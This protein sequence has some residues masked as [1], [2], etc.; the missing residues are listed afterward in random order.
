MRHPSF[1]RLTALAAGLLLSTAAA[2]ADPA[3]LARAHGQAGVTCAQCH[4]AGGGKVRLDD[5]ETA[6][7]AAC[8]KC[9]GDLATLGAGSKEAINAHASH[10]GAIACTVCHRGHEASRPYCMNCHAFEMKIPFASAPARPRAPRASRAERTDVVVVGSGAAGMVAALTARESGARV[11]VLEKQPVTGGN[12]M[13]AAGGM[14]AAGTPQQARLGI[15]DSVEL[16]REDT[17]KGGRNLGDPE[18][19]GILARE[20]AASVAYL[21]SLGAD[22]SDVG[23]LGGATAARAHRPSGGAAVGAHIVGVLRKA[24]ASRKV[25]VRVNS[26][27]VRLLEDKAGRVTGVEVEGL[28][29]GRY[30]IRAGAV[31]LAAGGFSSNPA[32]VA[33]Y[34]P[35]FQGMTS[36]NQPGATGDGLDLGEAIGG[37]LKHMDQIQIH[38]SVAAGSRILITEA[39]RGNG[40]ILVNREGR[41][42]F[43]EIGTRDAVSQAI[44]R[45]GGRSAWLVF[46]EGVRKSLKQIDGYFHLGL[47]KAGDTPETLAQTLGMP[48]AELRATLDAYNAAVDAKADAAFGR[49]DLPRALRT[50]RFFAIEVKPGI[51]YT[52]GGLRIDA[53]TRVLATDGAAIP[54]FYAA[55]EVTGGTHGANRL[56]GNSISQTITF[57]RIAGRNA[58]AFARP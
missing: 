44:L 20:S 42:F 18:L 24:A 4:P 51:H 3:S 31:V 21:E 17:L 13:L 16:M 12:S 34:Q 58:A 10:L 46:D 55:G 11:I 47:V 15:K 26:R 23:R 30:V 35:A 48:P 33:K 41:R 45:Q 9:H 28:H 6:P 38:P 27:V 39:V 50:P 54:G 40:A 53:G 25:D 37:G 57:G 19:V 7:N 56:G 22:L 14:N 2:A 8:V 32:R 49:A 5:N 52:M 29:R 36:S 1:P 43:N